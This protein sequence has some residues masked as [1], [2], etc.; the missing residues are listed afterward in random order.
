MIKVRM[1]SCFSKCPKHPSR[2]LQAIYTG[3][4]ILLQNQMFKCLDCLGKEKIDHSCFIHLEDFLEPF[5]E[6]ARSNWP[7]NDEEL[8]SE[9]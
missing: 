1:A 9:I 4:D 7:V 8:V 5:I 2:K 6:G 3:N